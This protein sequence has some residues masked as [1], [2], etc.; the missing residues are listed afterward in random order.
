MDLKESRAEIDRIDLEIGKLLK[1]RFTIAGQI[2][3]MKNTLDLEI[4]DLERD[5]RVLENYKKQAGGEL[6]EGFIEELVELILKYSKE[7]QKS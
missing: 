5:K 6:D 1:K 4:E 3:N 7:V 2:G